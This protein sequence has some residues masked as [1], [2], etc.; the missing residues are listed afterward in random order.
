MFGSGDG[1][2]VLGD[3]TSHGGTVVSAQSN[4]LLNGT[5]VAVVGDMVACPQKGHGV[6]PIVEGHPT[7]TLNGKSVA[8]HGCHT[9]CGAT[10]SSACGGVHGLG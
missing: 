5:P 9:A 7:I 10:L 3:T 2:I 6:C 8:F 1:I 4:Y